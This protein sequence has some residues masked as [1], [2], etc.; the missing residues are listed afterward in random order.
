MATQEDRK[1][2]DC[3]VVMQ[4]GVII[5]RTDHDVSV[6]VWHPWPVEYN[7]FFWFDVGKSHGM[8]LDHTKLMRVTSFR[9]PQCGLLREYAISNSHND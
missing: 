9:C 7:K 3:L 5:D 8:K 4:E 2:P 6:S 1:C